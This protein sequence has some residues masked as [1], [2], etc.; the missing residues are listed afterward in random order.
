MS[1]VASGSSCAKWFCAESWGLFCFFEKARLTSTPALQAQTI[2]ESS[3]CDS[4]KL[5]LC[6]CSQ[7]QLSRK[8]N[9][10]TCKTWGLALSSQPSM[11][12]RRWW[13]L[14]F[15]EYLRMYRNCATQEVCSKENGAGDLYTF[16]WRHF[17]PSRTAQLHPLLSTLRIKDLLYFQY[18]LKSKAEAEVN[19][20]V[21]K[22]VQ[23]PTGLQ[24]N[25][26]HLAPQHLG[27]AAQVLLA[28][29]LLAQ[30]TG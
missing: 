15:Q 6:K 19:V 10:F 17:S 30:L 8:L 13:C 3:I 18:Q 9:N 2:A 16:H 14:A 27:K 29:L 20:G 12:C 5:C 1:G 21:Q 28:R 26:Y 24:P 4:V 25:G 22:R 7:L 11:S 23:V